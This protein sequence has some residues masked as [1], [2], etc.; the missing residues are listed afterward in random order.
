[1]LSTEIIKKIEDFVYSKPRSTQEIAQHIKKNWRTA[2][3]YVEEIEKNFGTLSTRTFR[4]G[5]RG[6]L[7]IVYWATMEKRN[8]SIFQETLEQQINVGRWA[9]DFS[10]FD[11]FQHVPDSEKEIWIKEGENEVQA[12]RLEEFAEVLR[13]AKKQV[14]FFSGNLSFINYKDKKID[15]FAELE[16]LVK[17]GISV[18]VL[19]RVD[20]VSIK[21]VQKLL[22]LNYKHGKDLIEIRHREHPLRATIID[23]LMFNLKEVKKPTGRVNELDKK[24]FIFYNIKNKEWVEWITKIF[25]KMFFSSVGVDK[26]LNE[27]G[28][29]NIIN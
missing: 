20:V 1:M 6:A 17:R 23:N 24:I 25:W 9:E 12:G 29:L 19:C 8:N 22:S 4:G 11:I 10:C 26:R 5:T 16:N 7:K 13:E 27:L 21:N 15:V 28:K 2:D 3:R 14:L 18:K